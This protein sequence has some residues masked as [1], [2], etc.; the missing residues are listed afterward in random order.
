MSKEKKKITKNKIHSRN[1]NKDRYDLK[2]LTDLN[3]DLLNAVKP[4]IKGED[5]IDF[6]NPTAVKSLNKTLLHFYYGIEN[7]DFSDDN[8]CPS[9]PN[10]ADYIHYMAD[11]LMSS[12]FGTL[13]AGEK[14]TCYNLGIGAACIYPIIG[15]TDYDWN[16]IGS[17]IDENSIRSAQ[18]IV[19]KNPSLK[20]KIDCR[21]QNNSKDFFYGILTKDEKIDISICNPPL[22]T[23]EEEAKNHLFK[24]GKAPKETKVSNELIYEGGEIVFLQRYVKESKKFAKNCF[25]FS[26]L[27]NKP[28]NQKGMVSYLKELGATDTK[29]IPIGPGNKSSQIITWTFLSKAEQLEWKKI[30]WNTKK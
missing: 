4:N 26:I 7:W 17:D 13:P 28:S 21:L 6:T 18:S 29:V 24:K 16:F 27:V 10:R 20:G 1:R 19:S 5:T 9:I 11:V 25:W 23:S 14:I 2:A 12:N 22:Y 15:V 30:N 3:P 8:I